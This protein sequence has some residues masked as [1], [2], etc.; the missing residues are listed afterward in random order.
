[1]PCQIW[2]HNVKP[3]PFFSPKYFLLCKKKYN[4]FF[5]PFQSPPGRRRKQSSDHAKYPM[6]INLLLSC[7][8]WTEFFLNGI[9]FSHTKFSYVWFHSVFSLLI[10]STRIIYKSFC[11]CRFFSIYFC[12]CET[13]EEK[14]FFFT[15]K[16]VHLF[17][18]TFL[19]FLYRFFLLL[20]FFVFVFF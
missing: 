10:Y 5:S 1:M 13:F 17:F 9:F 12:L 7:C 20:L 18:C 3:Y 19:L 16:L 11:Y 2:I 8:C 15:K 6:Y 4:S 14:E